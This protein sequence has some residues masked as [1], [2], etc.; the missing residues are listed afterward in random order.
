MDIKKRNKNTKLTTYQ[1]PD[2]IIKNNF[3][4]IKNQLNAK[5]NFLKANTKRNVNSKQFNFED[6]HIPFPSSTINNKGKIVEN[7]KTIS[8]Q[9]SYSKNNKQIPT[10]FKNVISSKNSNNIDKL[11]NDKYNS[12]KKNS[13]ELIKT[14]SL[15]LMNVFKHKND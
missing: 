10:L 1:I 12:G 8:P 7:K 9:N 15:N 2:K 14:L 11:N 5:L 4:E 6:I 3:L 13:N